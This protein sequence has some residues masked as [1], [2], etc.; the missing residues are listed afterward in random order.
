LVLCAF[1]GACGVRRGEPAEAL[2]PGDWKGHCEGPTSA[3]AWK[4]SASHG[5]TWVD[6]QGGILDPGAEAELTKNLEAFHAET[7]HQFLVVTKPSLEGRSIAAVAQ[8]LATEI[9]PGYPGFNNGLILLI[10]VKERQTRIE[11][12]CG[13]EDVITPQQAN[14]IMQQQLL[15][16]LGAGDVYTAVKE[17]LAALEARARTKVIPPAYRPAGCPKAP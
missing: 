8:S 16:T 13:L 14:E 2:P 3:G 5:V 9:G 1:L 10:T 11:I 4:K 12:G 17:A 7:C 6:D 15:P